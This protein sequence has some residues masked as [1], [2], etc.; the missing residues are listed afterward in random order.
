[1]AQSNKAAD[2][3][4]VLDVSKS[5]LAED[6]APNRMKRAKSE[7]SELVEQLSGHRIGLV[8]FAGRICTT[9][10]LPACRHPAF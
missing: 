6:A 10:Q 7:I 4:V 9:A 3:M 2:I 8:G 1:M 5:M